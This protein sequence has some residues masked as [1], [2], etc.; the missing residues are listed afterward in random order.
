MLDYLDNIY[1]MKNKYYNLMVIWVILFFLLSACV[2]KLPDIKEDVLKQTDASLF[3]KVPAEKSKINF[4][5]AITETEEDN[6]FIYEY[7]YNGGGVAVG[8]VNNDGLQDLF[9]TGNQVPNTLYL[10]HGNFVFEDVTKAYNLLDDGSW[11]TGA[12]F[13]DV[14]NDGFL[15]LYV[16]N[17]KLKGERQN[18]LFIN[19]GDGTFKESGKEF[20]VA[21]NGFSTHATFLDYDKDGDLDLYVVNHSPLRTLSIEVQQRA[22][23]GKPKEI[24]D[25]FYENIEGKYFKNVSAEVGIMPYYAFGLSATSS[26]INSDGWPDIYVTNDYDEPDILYLNDTKGRFIRSE[27]RAT[28]HIS[29]FGMGSDIADFNNDL[30]PDIM[31][32]D[33]TAEDNRRKKLNM[34][35]MNPELFW[36]HVEK[37]YHYQYMHNTL[38]LNQGNDTAGVPVFSEVAQ[39][40]N[41]AFTD[42]SWSVLFADFDN[43]GWKDLFITNGYLRLRNNDFKLKKQKA[44][45]PLTR[46]EQID[47]LE[48]EGT[49]NYAFQNQGGLKFEN[50]AKNWGVDYTGFS[51][52]AAYADLDNDGDL[53]YIINNINDKASIYENRANDLGPNYYLQIELEG[54]ESNTFGVGAKVK[55]KVNGKEQLQELSLSRGFLSSTPPMLHFGLGKERAIDELEV[56]WPSGKK[57]L[58]INVAADQ[59][60]LLR[61]VDAKTKGLDLNDN[62]EEQLFKALSGKKGLEFEHQENDYD[63]F[64]KEVLLPHKMSNFGPA[65]A[66]GDIN[67][68]GLED[69]Y[70]GGAANQQGKLFVQRKNSDFSAIVPEVFRKDAFQEDV[71]A[72]IFDANGDGRQDIYVVSGGNEKEDGSPFYQDRLYLNGKKAFTKAILPRM[73]SSGSCVRPYDYDGDGDLD[74]FVGGRVKAQK[75]PLAGNSYILENKGDGVYEDVTSSI[76]SELSNIGMVTDALW[77]D[78]NNDGAIDLVLTGE[79][80]S[81]TFFENNDGKFKNTTQSSGLSNEKGWWFSMEQGD[82]DGDGDQDYMAGNLGLNYKYKAA[83]DKPFKIHAG[84]LDGNGKHDIVLGYFNQGELYPVR[85][86][87]CS[88]QQMPILKDKFESYEAFGTATLTDVYG[89]K[90]LKNSMLLEVTNFASSYIEN[91]GNGK[92]R[93]APLPAEAQLSSI[94]DILIEDFDGD[95]FKDA[96][97]AGNLYAS[98][99]ETTRNDAGTGVFLKGNGNGNFKA[100]RYRETGL[101]LRDDIKKMKMLQGKNERILIVGNN[102]SSLQ[103]FGFVR[104][105]TK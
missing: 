12:T 32:A 55:I 19:S 38:Q 47:L 7:F 44:E 43:D 13:A 1:E 50:K 34:A 58:L 51:N 57:Q 41:V 17:A 8:D 21:D 94:N 65:L 103:S 93:L 68:D 75:Y 30:M 83:E 28:K 42:W 80:M 85:G 35:S 49:A 10:N 91:L 97:V 72:V 71:A 60:L 18:K 67:G 96:I 14:N 23:K 54:S 59:K 84:D 87:Q 52:G 3:N 9:F 29:L 105:N 61:E 95:G 40:S 22:R 16:C 24:S 37:G 78:F 69:F 63:D 56:I 20:N 89:E 92:F 98:E 82:F 66:I 79:W 25:Q 5:N 62:S 77:S 26:D 104:K 86:L 39:F 53:D 74:L 4:N 33:M 81:P 31:V 100:L 102:N 64:D 6:V 11:F 70:I 15:D 73:H 2:E 36:D 45:R 90:N 88:S 27:K 99:V 46:L 48:S 76:A 101:L